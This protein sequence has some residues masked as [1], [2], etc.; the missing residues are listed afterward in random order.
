MA[1]VECERFQVVS[2]VDGRKFTSAPL[3]RAEAER[4]A[5][6]RAR[7]PTVESVEVVAR[8]MYA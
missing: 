6:S 2:Y 7:N 5:D 4:E 8:T 1:E 3:P